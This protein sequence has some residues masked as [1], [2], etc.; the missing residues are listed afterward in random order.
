MRK[1]SAQLRGDISRRIGNVLTRRQNEQ[2]QRML[3]EPYDFSKLR[4]EQVG[5]R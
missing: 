1:G 4:P 5:R 2:L 3:G